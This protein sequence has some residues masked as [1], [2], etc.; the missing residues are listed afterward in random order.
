MRNQGEASHRR[1][2]SRLR[3][4]HR[5]PRNWASQAICTPRRSL[6]S[7]QRN[8]S[9]Q[10]TQRKCQIAARSK[11]RSK[12]ADFSSTHH[13][14]LSQAATKKR[15]WR[16]CQPRPAPIHRAREKIRGALRPR[17]QQERTVMKKSELLQKVLTIPEPRLIAAIGAVLAHRKRQAD[18]LPD[19]AEVDVR[20]DVA[21]FLQTCSARQLRML[22]EIASGLELKVEGRLQ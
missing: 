9:L 14:C 3:S 13:F 6:R 18:G 20:V 5:A 8:R 19:D 15:K 10:G 12:N 7:M 11:L 17:T 4:Q 21:A 2:F 16:P 1:P 22:Q